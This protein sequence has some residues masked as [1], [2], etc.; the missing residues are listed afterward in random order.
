MAGLF[1]N[2]GYCYL[3]CRSLVLE[4]YYENVTIYD[5][6]CPVNIATICYKP[7]I[8]QVSRIVESTMGMNST[9][10]IIGAIP[11]PQGPRYPL[12]GWKARMRGYI[13]QWL[14]YF[15]PL[16]SILSLKERKLT[17]QQ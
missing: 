7:L 3:A 5:H 1:Y 11:S 14:V 4:R 13:N 10:Q 9:G 17:G 8:A 12:V 2:I 15:Y 16:T 6:Y